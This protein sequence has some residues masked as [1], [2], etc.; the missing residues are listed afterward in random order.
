MD[1]RNIAQKF[2]DV[3]S[4]VEGADIKNISASVVFCVESCNW[5]TEVSG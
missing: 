5:K 4:E 2:V 3:Y 1:T